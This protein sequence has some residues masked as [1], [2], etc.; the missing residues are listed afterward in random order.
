M[1]LYTHTA[2]TDGQL[3]FD[4]LMTYSVDIVIII[5]NVIQFKLF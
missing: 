3:Q 5:F 1:K 4:H 2:S